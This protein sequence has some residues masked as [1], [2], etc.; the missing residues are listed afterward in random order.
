MWKEPYNTAIMRSICER[1]KFLAFN[2]KPGMKFP[3]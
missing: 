1:T 3:F 2:E